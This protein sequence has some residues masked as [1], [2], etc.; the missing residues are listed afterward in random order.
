MAVSRRGSLRHNVEG[1]GAA[2]P[3]D[4]PCAS[5][6][7]APANEPWKPRSLMCACKGGNCLPRVSCS[8]MSTICDRQLPCVI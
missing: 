8:W 3:P 6:P 4:R 2:T 5:A 1:A 7:I